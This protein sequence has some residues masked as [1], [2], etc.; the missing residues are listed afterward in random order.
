MDLGTI[1]GCRYSDAALHVQS[2]MQGVL[3]AALCL[4][5][6][7]A[8]SSSRSRL[9]H[10]ASDAPTLGGA[11][12]FYP[13]SLGLVIQCSLTRSV[14]EA[15]HS[16]PHQERNPEISR[17]KPERPGSGFSFPFLRTPL[18]PLLPPAHV[19]TICCSVQ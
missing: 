11:R 4:A 1:A 8:F 18:D 19:E 3:A 7:R 17:R 6:P 2:A 5:F 10:T 9:W 15:R 14:Q 12:V 16:S 13:R